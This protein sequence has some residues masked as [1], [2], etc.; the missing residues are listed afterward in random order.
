MATISITEQHLYLALWTFITSLVGQDIP[1]VQ[2]VQNRVATPAGD[3]IVMTGLF[4]PAL[5]TTTQ[6]YD[7]D[8]GTATNK[9]SKQWTAQVDCYGLTSADNA[10]MIVQMLRTPYGAE[11]FEL[12]GLEIAPLFSSDARQLAMATGEDEY[13]ERW[14]FEVALQYN[15]E[16]T[17]SQQSAD[18]LSVGI[19]E[20]N[21][22][23]GP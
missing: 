8:A 9:Q 1:V 7:G 11:Q 4:A 14:T 5:A 3:Y 10:A 21:R 18:E 16:I 23:Y 22:A 12:S 19:I 6:T 15:P 13:Q 20:A 17:V 2:G